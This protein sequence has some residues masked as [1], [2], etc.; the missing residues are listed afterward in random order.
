MEKTCG[1]GNS[2]KIEGVQP[3][4]RSL[5]TGNSLRSSRPCHAGSVDKM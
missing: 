1:F 4:L 5:N 3:Y 2:L